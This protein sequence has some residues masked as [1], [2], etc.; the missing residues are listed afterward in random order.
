MSSYGHSTPYNE[1]DT[2]L[3]NK[4]DTK[5]LPLNNYALT[6]VKNVKIVKAWMMRNTHEES[7]VEIV[8][9]EGEN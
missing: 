8:T 6:K 4:C 3:R 1:D 5:E 7:E 9:D 2:C